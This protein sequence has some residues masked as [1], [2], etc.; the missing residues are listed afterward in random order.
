[1]MKFIIPLLLGFAILTSPQGLPVWIAK[2]EIIAVFAPR[3]GECT[4]D[5]HAVVVT[6]SITFCVA[7]DA[8]DVIQKVN[9]E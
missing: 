8:D 7:E 9:E 6:S 3:K 4:D 5:S 2:S 1:M